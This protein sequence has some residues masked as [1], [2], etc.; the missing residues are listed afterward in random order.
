MVLTVST[1]YLA[2]WCSS[3]N[4]NADDWAKSQLL[5]VLYA[6]LDATNNSSLTSDLLKVA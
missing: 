3:R 1:G 2:L 6:S 4:S 5:A